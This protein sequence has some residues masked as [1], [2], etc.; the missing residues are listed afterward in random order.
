MQFDGSEKLSPPLQTCNV[1]ERL[2]FH[3]TSQVQS[4]KYIFTLFYEC[5]SDIYL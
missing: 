4:F 5:P 1:Q 2:Q 3:Q